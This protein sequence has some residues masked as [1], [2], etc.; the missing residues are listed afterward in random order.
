MCVFK[1]RN[2]NIL[3]SAFESELI[4]PTVGIAWKQNMPLHPVTE[5]TAPI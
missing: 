4:T 3:V 2:I 1:K 5:I